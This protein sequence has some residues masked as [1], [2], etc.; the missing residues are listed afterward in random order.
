M[1]FNDLSIFGLHETINS[2]A[3][4]LECTGQQKENFMLVFILIVFTSTS[5]NLFPVLVSIVVSI[6]AGDRGSIPRR[7]ALLKYFSMLWSKKFSHP[8]TL[9]FASCWSLWMKCCC[10]VSGKVLV[11]SWPIW[12]LGWWKA[13]DKRFESNLHLLVWDCICETFLLKHLNEF[14]A[15]TKRNKERKSITIDWKQLESSGTVG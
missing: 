8:Y 12:F 5:S 1:Y 9:I 13:F 11:W 2:S 10:C 3:Y 4:Q 14:Y 7:W 15:C 6:H